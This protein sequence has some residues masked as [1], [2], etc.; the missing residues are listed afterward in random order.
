MEISTKISFLL[1]TAGY[2]RQELCCGASGL[3]RKTK[4]SGSHKTFLV[5]YTR[6]K[7]FYEGDT[8]SITLWVD[9]YLGEQ[10][11]ATR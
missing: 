5:A 6:N 10:A 2:F 9:F 7:S 4:R 8:V 1:H 11:P 3:T